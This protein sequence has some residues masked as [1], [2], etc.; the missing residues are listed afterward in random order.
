MYGDIT[1]QLPERIK[2]KNKKTLTILIAGVQEC[3]AVR[4]T[5]GTATLE[6]SGAVSHKTKHTFNIS[7]SNCAGWYLPNSFYF[8]IYFPLFYFI[9]FSLIFISWRLIILQ[10]SS[11]FCH[12]LT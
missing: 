1:T 12:T 4:N 8:F 3:I 7:S 9:L 6:E 11:G 2:Q 10:Y 5:K